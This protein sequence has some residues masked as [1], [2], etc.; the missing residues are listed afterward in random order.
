MD[1]RDTPEEA[2]FRD[3][4][5][6]WLEAN[7]PDEPPGP[8]RRRGE[9]RRARGARVEPRPLRRRLG[10]HLLAGGVRRP[11]AR[12]ALP[13]DLPR[14]GGARGGPAAHRR[15]RARDGG[16]DDH[17]AGH[18]GAE[19]PVPAAAAGRGGDL[20]PGL[21][22]TGSR[23]R[24]GGRPHRPPGSRATASCSTARRSSPRTHIADFCILL[25][26]SDFSSE[27]H[28]GLTYVIVDMRAP[29][30]GFGRSGR[31]RARPSSAR[32]S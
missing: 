32:S 24:P 19:G 1:F 16:P 17:H 13:G 25:A 4:V 26:R 3:E 6:T 12:A 2:R 15:D 28:A 23:L 20:V 10:R 5:R 21:L 27:R 31:S 18:G 29:G 9:V 8:P 7:L 30:V 22:G 14:G 11:R